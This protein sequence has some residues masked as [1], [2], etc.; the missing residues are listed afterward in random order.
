[1]QLVTADNEFG[2][3]TEVDTDESVK[4][5]PKKKTKQDVLMTVKMM[6]V[7]VVK[8]A[9]LL[10]ENVNLK[11]VPILSNKRCKKVQTN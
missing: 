10:R 9:K 11:L 1:M 7:V 6:M 5:Q 3:G 8:K 2:R 4:A